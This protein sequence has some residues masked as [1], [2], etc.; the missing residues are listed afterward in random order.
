MYS[1]RLILLF[2]NPLTLWLKW[3]VKKYW[4]EFKYRKQHLFIDYMA[5]VS[6]CRFEEYNTIYK[7]TRLYHCGL[8]ACTYISKDCQIQF[9]EIGRFCSIGPGV[10]IGLGIHPA[11]TFVST[12]PV[13]FSTRRQA[14]LSF[15]TENRFEEYKTTTIGNDVWIGTNAVIRDGI[16]IGN[17]AIIGAGAVVTKDVP[18]YAIVGGVPTTIIRYRFSPEEIGFLESFQWWNKDLNWIREN[19]SLFSDIKKLRDKYE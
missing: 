13:F 3:F 1:N 9:A 8:G 6:H 4:L 15:L 16:T 7:N 5:D 18:P 17:G 12:H 11:N 2:I 19:S 10:K 14:Q